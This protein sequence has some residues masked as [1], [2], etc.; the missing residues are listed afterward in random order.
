MGRENPTSYVENPA[1][2]IIEYDAKKGLF[3]WYNKDKGETVYL[4][5][6]FRAVWVEEMCTVGGYNKKTKSRIMGNETKGVKDDMQAF[7]FVKIGDEYE[8]QTIA[9]GPWADIK[10]TVTSN[11]V[12]GKFAKYIY[13][14]SD[15]DN[16]ILK[17]GELF[18]LFVIGCSVSAWFDKGFNASCGGF[19][20]Y[21]T[22]DKVNGD[23]EYKEPV[24]KQEQISSELNGK[25]IEA[26][27]LVQSWINQ[28]ASE[29]ELEK[30]DAPVED[31]DDV[32]F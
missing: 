9:D 19:A 13:A 22:I 12:G 11:R 3:K 10:D 6:P 29:P 5:L 24:F 16:A 20:V 4:D 27:R 15:G 30:P 21:E 23:T 1:K 14:V 28:D 25:A 26:D 17:D 18:K 8:R 32:Q 2:K 31:E 7:M